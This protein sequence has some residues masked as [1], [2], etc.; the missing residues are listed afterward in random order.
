MWFLFPFY[1]YKIYH[2]LVVS[3]LFFLSTNNIPHHI[4]FSPT[5]Q[6]NGT[7]KG[8]ESKEQQ[9]QVKSIRLRGLNYSPRQGPDS[10]GEYKC[11][12]TQRIR[13]ELLK[14][15]KLTDKLHLY[16]L[17]DCDQ[18]R[19]LIPL[20]RELG[21]K[22]F[23]NMW[24]DA[25]PLSFQR[26]FEEL[27]YL[28]QHNLLCYHEYDHHHQHN[29]HQNHLKHRSANRGD[30]NVVMGISVGSEMLYRGEVSRAQGLAYVNQVR[31]LLLRSH[32]DTTSNNEM[33]NKSKCGIPVTITD[34]DKVYAWHNSSLVVNV[35]FCSV[36]AFPFF[37]PK[38][39]GQSAKDGAVDHLLHCIDPIMN[40]ARRLNKSF[41]LTE[42]GW[43]S[44]GTECGAPT[45]AIASPEDQI[46]YFT[47]FYCK[48][49]VAQPDLQ[50]F[51]FNGFDA[52][53]R[54]LQD[55]SQFSVEGHFGMLEE[56]GQMKRHFRELS[57]TCPDY[58]G[59]KTYRM[60][61]L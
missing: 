26:E 58:S 5:F 36:N 55:A 41:F 6:N 22:I 46:A 54:R 8:K 61:K 29:Y 45:C 39:S 9:L 34:I 13:S 49:H 53:W 47:D 15:S 37:D 42:T 48:V 52:A 33:V 20:A 12:P 21:F 11:T 7:S 57:F 16:I 19:L 14:L 27:E 32:D 28:M 2:I 25:N 17:T 43:P 50:Y 35:D 1:Q 10:W 3:L 23:L 60:P 56:D 24:V 44:A 38:F 40:E 51:W 18:A 4:K 31:N 59:D 30:Q